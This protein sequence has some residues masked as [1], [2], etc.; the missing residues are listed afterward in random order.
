MSSGEFNERFRQG[1]VEPHET[2]TT[3]PPLPTPSARVVQIAEP[4]LHTFSE[5]D[6]SLNS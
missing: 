6:L 3:P 5:D 1:G 4:R 2:L